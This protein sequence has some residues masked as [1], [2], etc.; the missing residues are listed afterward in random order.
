MT[1]AKT[2]DKYKTDSEDEIVFIH[3]MKEDKKEEKSKEH[4]E[5]ES[6]K[7]ENSFLSNLKEQSFSNSLMGGVNQSKLSIKQLQNRSKL[8]AIKE[9][10]EENKIIVY[11]TDKDYLKRKPAL[12][13]FQF[14]Y[15]ENEAI[16]LNQKANIKSYIICPGVIYGYGEKEFYYIFKNALLGKHVEEILLDKGRNIIPTI[17]MKDLV[18]IIAKVIEKKPL[19][20]YILAFD[21][22]KDCSLKNILK[23]VSFLNNPYLCNILLFYFLLFLLL[24]PIIY[25]YFVIV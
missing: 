17:H 1:W 14:K 25:F 9:E 23:P 3:P 18:N 7:R 6:M 8:S 5:N 22:N 2:P 20:N 10:K 12:K 11:Y 21:Q 13:Y 4:K 24:L 16:N 19:S 15:I